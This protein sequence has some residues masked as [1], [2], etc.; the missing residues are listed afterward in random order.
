MEAPTV[1]VRIR[2]SAIIAEGSNGSIVQLTPSRARLLIEAGAVDMI[3]EQPVAGPSEIKPSG[4]TEKKSYAV[5]AAGQLTDSAVSI[6]S[7]KTKPSSLLAVDQALAMGK[8]LQS[9][10]PDSTKK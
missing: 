7:G 2:R 8:S 9:K 4:P 1:K 6:E 10:K 3:D 5:P